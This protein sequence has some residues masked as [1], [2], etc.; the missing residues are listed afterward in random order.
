MQDG[1]FGNLPS[2]EEKGMKKEYFVL[3]YNLLTLI[4]FSS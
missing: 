4:F 1:K 2:F 3:L